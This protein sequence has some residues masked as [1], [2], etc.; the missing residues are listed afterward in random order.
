MEIFSAPDGNH[1]FI[2][3]DIYP[4][5]DEIKHQNTWKTGTLKCYELSDIQFNLTTPGL[6]CRLKRKRD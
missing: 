4:I 5:R 3:D 6:K 2:G 1:N